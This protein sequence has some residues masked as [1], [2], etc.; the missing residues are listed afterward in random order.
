MF[1]VIML[2]G[3]LAPGFP[4]EGEIMSSWTPPNESVTTRLF[5]LALT[6]VLMLATVCAHA[7][8]GQDEATA[9]ADG[10]RLQAR[11]TKRA[12]AGYAVHEILLGSGTIVREYA[13][14]EGKIFAVTWRGPTLPNLGQILGEANFQSFVGSPGAQHV[15]RRLRAVQRDD[16]V[17][18]S[19][20][21]P[22]AFSGYAY[23]PALV[24][25][26]VAVENLR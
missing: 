1:L 3:I 14:P 25:S 17:V 21:R 8:L 18:H 20:G 23:V 19:A 11:R 13:S 10:N 6:S 9:D 24:P 4:A 12:E 7:T 22:R 26:G 16:L 2:C 5:A 15:R